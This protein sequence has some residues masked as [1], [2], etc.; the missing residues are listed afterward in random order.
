MQ[1][2]ADSHVHIRFTRKEEI[3][4][5]LDD[6]AAVGVTDACLL[7]LPYHGASENLAALYHKMHY[8]KMD[9]R[10]FAGLHLTDRYATIAPEVQAKALLDMGF[11]GLKMR[12]AP[13]FPQFYKRRINE[14]CLDPLFT[15]M[16]ERD[17]PMNIHVNDPEE[18]W[19]TGGNYSASGYITKQ[20]LYADIFDV[21]DRHPALRVTFA[22]FFFL[23]NSPFEAERV[24]QTYPNVWF[25]LTPGVEMYYNFDNNL[26]YWHD[27]FT[28]YKDRIMFGT[29]SNTYKTSN[30]DLVRL[31][32]RK[33]TESEDLFTQRCYDHD[34]VV[35]GL[36]LDAE[37]VDHICYRN[38]HARLGAKVPVDIERFYDG[39]ARVLHD[40][41]TKP[42]DP[43]YL[44]GAHLFTH[45][46]EDPYQTIPADFCRKVL[47][48]RREQS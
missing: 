5:M 1:K 34:F 10:A 4:R 2:I 27:F 18:F 26:P 40:I 29:D 31:V 3:T 45:L 43:Y 32:Y 21:L 7:S 12:Y 42:F 15:L 13:E 37:T 19:R 47:Q 41:E 46:A 35:R 14:K 23:S 22:H 30:Q 11:D 28:R 39:C 9:V 38:Y 25:D 17:V 8:T 6:L 44:A 48:E 24:M 20:E 36:A 33:L 16:E